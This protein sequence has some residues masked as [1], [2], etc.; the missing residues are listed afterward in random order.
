MECLVQDGIFS[1]G[2]YT[3]YSIYY[4]VYTIVMGCLVMGHLVMGRFV[5]ES[6]MYSVEYMS[7]FCTVYTYKYTVYLDQEP[8][9]P[10]E[11]LLQQ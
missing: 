11:V 8:T 10:V 4:I 1:I 9:Y 7:G 5:Y 2:M 6:Y 3:L